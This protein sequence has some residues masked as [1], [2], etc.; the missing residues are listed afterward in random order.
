ML[1]F[2]HDPD[3]GCNARF[4]YE[5]VTFP[6]ISQSPELFGWAE[7]IGY[8]AAQRSAESIGVLCYVSA[9]FQI[10][11]SSN[12]CLSLLVRERIQ[13]AIAEHQFAAEQLLF[14]SRKRGKPLKQRLRFLG[15]GR[16]PNLRTCMRGQKAQRSTEQC[17]YMRGDH[18]CPL[19][20]LPERP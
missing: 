6:A 8:V 5:T 18:G 9:L 19:T 10:S 2:L 16:W 4:V 15:L 17:Q 7:G 1:L 20:K 11:V 14:S 3:V 12:S 13:I